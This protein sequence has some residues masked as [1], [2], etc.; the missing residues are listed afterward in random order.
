MPPY[1]VPTDPREAMWHDVA[2]IKLQEEVWIHANEEFAIG[3]S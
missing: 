3:S 1:F 2:R